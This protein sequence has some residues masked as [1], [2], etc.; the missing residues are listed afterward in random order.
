MRAQMQGCMKPDCTEQQ[1]LRCEQCR[2]AAYC[3]ERHQAQDFGRHGITECAMLG[4]QRPCVRCTRK[5]A[6]TCDRCDDT[7][8]EMLLAPI[9]HGAVMTGRSLCARC[10]E[11]FDWCQGCEAE[12]LEQHGDQPQPS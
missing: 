3:C 4:F 10:D 1:T 8:S 9:A 6:L 11:Q 2:V 12:Y 7:Y 5:T